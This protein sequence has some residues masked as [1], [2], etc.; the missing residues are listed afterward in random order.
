MGSSSDQ[1]SLLYTYVHACTRSTHTRTHTHTQHTHTHTAHTHTAHTHAHTHTHMYLWKPP[2]LDE[3]LQNFFV[4]EG[5]QNIAIA[6]GCVEGH[7]HCVKVVVSGR[8]RGSAR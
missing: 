4:E 6:R 3:V 8:R 7:I 5:L 2:V 1:G